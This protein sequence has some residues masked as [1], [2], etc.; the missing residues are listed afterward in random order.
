MQVPVD[1]DRSVASRIAHILSSR[2]V[3]GALKPG[4][5]VRQDH[6]AVEFRASHVPVREAFRMLEGQGLLVSEPRRGVRV[7]PLDPATVHEITQIR[8]ALECLALKHAMP[9]MTPDAL[10]KAELALNGGEQSNDIAVWE[11]ANR[12]FHKAL[13]EPCAMPRVLA[14]LDDLHRTS[15]R[16]LYAAWQGLGWQP[17]SEH[18]HRAIL[19]HVKAGDTEVA[20]QLLS[21]HIVAAGEALI[22][23]LIAGSGTVKA[24]IVTL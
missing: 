20:L 12:R 4:E 1:D 6:I 14:Q 11:S 21:L 15:A 8:A 24:V 10:A 3:T 5:P 7:A 13:Y 16:F 22:E 17:R 18:E 2:I 23:N 19:A 9:K